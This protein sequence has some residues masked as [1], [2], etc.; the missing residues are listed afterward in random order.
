MPCRCQRCPFNTVHTP[1]RRGRGSSEHPLRHCISGVAA[2]CPQLFVA[3]THESAAHNYGDWRGHDELRAA[4]A[5]EN[6]EQQATAGAVGA[7]GGRPEA[8]P[9]R[10]EEPPQASASALQAATARPRRG[11]C[12]PVQAAPPCAAA[13]RARPSGQPR[14]GRCR[15]SRPGAPG[16]SAKRSP[17]PSPPWRQ[18]WSRL[19]PQRRCA[20]QT[21]GL[22]QARRRL[23]RAPRRRRAA[24][25]PSGPRL[26]SGRSATVRCRRGSPCPTMPRQTCAPSAWRRRSTRALESATSRAAWFSRCVPPPLSAG[27]FEVG[28]GGH[29]LCCAERCRQLP[30]CRASVPKGAA[31]GSGCTPFLQDFP[32]FRPNLTPKQVVQAGSFGG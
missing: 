24:L 19:L 25:P 6:R 14:V 27:L 26:T 2:R 4:A 17:T 15:W 21:P 22:G 30:R 1:P 16:G 28:H 7:A 5:G 13:G 23:W 3:Q 11:P 20:V 29:A 9:A 10:Q 18:S 32:A 8:G 31:W 12:L